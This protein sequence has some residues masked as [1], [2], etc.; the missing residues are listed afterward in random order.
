MGTGHSLC[1]H[2]AVFLPLGGPADHVRHLP[3]VLVAIYGAGGPGV[4]RGLLSLC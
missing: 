4:C 1:P 3:E 2:L